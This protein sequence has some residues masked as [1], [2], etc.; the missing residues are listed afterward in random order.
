MIQRLVRDVEAEHRQ[1]FEQYQYRLEYHQICES[2]N[3][4]DEAR[5]ET[6]LC[7]PMWREEVEAR[8]CERW[9]LVV[10]KVNAVLEAKTDA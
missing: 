9:L 5:R 8:L 10:R 2:P 6:N 1:S 4:E 3:P 7:I